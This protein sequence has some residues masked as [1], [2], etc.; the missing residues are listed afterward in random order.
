MH[1]V[2]YG[3]KLV[4]VQGNGRVVLEKGGQEA[5]D[6]IPLDVASVVQVIYAEGDCRASRSMTQG[7]CTKPVVHA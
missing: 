6:L 7:T 3:F 5:L 4:I 1:L 2:H